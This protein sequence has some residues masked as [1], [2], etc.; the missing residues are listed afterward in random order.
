[1]DFLP[2]P[3]T[4]LSRQISPS[5]FAEVRRVGAKPA[6]S[7][8][9]TPDIRVSRLPADLPPEVRSQLEFVLETFP[10]PDAIGRQIMKSSAIA[11]VGPVKPNSLPKPK[12]SDK[13]R[14]VPS[15]PQTNPPTG[16][17]S[18]DFKPLVRELEPLLRNLLK[19]DSDRQE[20]DL[21]T[22]V[23]TAEGNVVIRYKKS[24]LKADRIR[25]NTKTQEVT[26]EGNVFFTRGDQRIRGT[27]LTYNYRTVKGELLNTSGAIDI[28]TLQSYEVSQSP[29]K[30]APNSVTFSIAGTGDNPEGQVRRFGFV[31]DRLTLD[32]DTWIAENLR[33]TNDPFYPP[34]LE[35]AATKATLTPTSQTKS[36]LDLE[37]PRLIFDQGFFLTLPVTSIPLDGF[38]RITPIL[39]GFDRA[40]RGGAFY[41]QSFDLIS[42]PNL[43]F[44]LSPQLLI[45]RAFSSEKGSGFS[46]VDVFGLLAT[47]KG[48]FD[49]GQTLSAT[50][51]LSGLDFSRLDTLLR[52][53]FGHMIPVFGNHRLYSQYTFRDRVFNGSLGFQDINNIFGSTLLSPNYVLGD[54]EISL[55]YRLSAQLIDALRSDLLPNAVSSLIRLQSSAILSRTFPLW[56]G[57]P[58][59]AERDTGLRFS[60]KP[61]VPK[62]DAFL[63]A[64]GVNSY[65]SNGANQAVLYGTAGLSAEIGNFAKDLFD[66][67]GLNVSY[68]HAFAGGKSPFYFDQVVDP[69]SL[70]AGI[71]QQIYGPFRL[72]IQ[73]SWN[74]DTGNAYDSVYSL[75]YARRTYSVVIRYSPSQGLGEFLLRISDF[76]WTKPP[77]N[78]TTIQN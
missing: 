15:P 11:Q 49:D 28:G 65:Y 40:D 68:T 44:Q 73:Q 2:P 34:E 72:G 31:A 9:P 10:D 22:Q 3:S 66:Y 76:N 70:S 58:A 35:L 19:I 59:P 39:V 12:P 26:A 27:K 23:F 52:F 33:L 62:L 45:Q 61:V 67:T 7:S 37:S 60:P 38:T 21:N 13:P 16:K 32:Q 50:A 64:Q 24:E 71:V 77:E 25:L 78:M 14:S 36:R 8:S 56:R 30:T 4:E 46:S 20:Y 75:E 48:S 51:S 69:R 47:L 17:D 18:Q 6:L 53:N 42:Q 63:S 41:Q 54:S 5:T 43:S 55:S 29:V 57:E 74:L 1:M